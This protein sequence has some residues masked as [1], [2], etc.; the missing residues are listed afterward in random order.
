MTLK[1]NYLFVSLLHLS[2]TIL[3][4]QSPR[5]G[6]NNRPTVLPSQPPAPSSSVPQPQHPDQGRGLA[7]PAVTTKYSPPP[8]PL[9]APVWLPQRSKTK[10]GQEAFASGSDN[11]REN[12]GLVRFPN[13]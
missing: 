2:L 1:V 5:P 7:T 3:Q 11:E 8:A 12:R 9:V 10:A 13:L 6:E 4:L